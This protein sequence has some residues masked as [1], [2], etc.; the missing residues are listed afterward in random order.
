MAKDETIFEGL[1]KKCT[2][3]RQIF[4][5][6]TALADNLSADEVLELRAKYTGLSLA[7]ARQY[8][9]AL[10]TIKAIEAKSAKKQ[11]GEMYHCIIN[12]AVSGY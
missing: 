5:T 11:L 2:T 12:Y 7:E 3:M 9:N 4:D 10:D 1:L 6:Q 8:A